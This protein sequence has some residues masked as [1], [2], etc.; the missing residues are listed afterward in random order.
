[1]DHRRRD[2]TV[3]E[4]LHTV[5][6]PCSVA[7]QAPLSVI[8]LGLIQG[9]EWEED[10]LLRVH[11]RVTTSGCT[12]VGNIMRAIETSLAQRCPEISRV[13]VEVHPEIFWTPEFI[14]AQGKELLARRRRASQDSKAIRPR[15]W[16][17]RA[18]PAD[19]KAAGV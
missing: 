2:D 13:E 14:S 9:W 19:G 18:R 8:D 10:G 11:M 4:V 17:D 16:Q 5:F 15:Q 7:A 3:T 6:D 1:M 12:M